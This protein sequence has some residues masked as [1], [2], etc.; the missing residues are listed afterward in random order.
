[1]DILANN[2]AVLDHK[3][4]LNRTPLY[5]AASNGFTE[6][7]DYLIDKGCDVNIPS[8]MGR[9]AIGKACWNGAISTV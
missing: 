6:I 4:L 5:W 3:E 7:I 8:S 9:T 2:G 1:M